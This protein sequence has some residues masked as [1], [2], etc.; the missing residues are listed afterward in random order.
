M[1][2]TNI[3]LSIKDLTVAFDKKPILWD[4]DLDITKG[5]LT[6]IVGPNGAGKST[7]LKAALG[8]IPPTAGR[9]DI[10][11]Q[12]FNRQRSQIAYSPQRN[13]VDW[14]FPTTV[15]DVVLMGTY[16]D[17]GW[18]NRPGKLER[19]RAMDALEKVS[20]Q[21]FADRQISQLSGGQQQRV[22]LARALVQNAAIYIM[23]E[24]F[25]GVDAVT[26]KAIITLLKDLR[27]QQK[28]M[29]VVHHDLQTIEDYFDWICLLNVRQIAYGKISDTFTEENL[30]LTYGGRHSTIPQSHT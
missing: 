2:P 4:I 1:D 24:P 14:D 13:E 21:P 19:D 30:R 7:L 29:I 18:F 20:M 27:N 28:T 15:L 25:V 26:E 16:G 22:F 3:A 8:I 5:T 9:V 10:F 11:G 23:D 6:A 12:P 17:L